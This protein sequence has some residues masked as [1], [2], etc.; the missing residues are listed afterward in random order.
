M[1]KIVT[2]GKKTLIFELDPNLIPRTPC[3]VCL[4]STI[5]MYE[6]L[7]WLIKIPTLQLARKVK[8]QTLKSKSLQFFKMLIIYLNKIKSI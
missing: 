8:M 2:Y 4:S 7:T 6:Q 3:H 5:E 1:L